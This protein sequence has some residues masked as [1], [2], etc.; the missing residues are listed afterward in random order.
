MTNSKL[1]TL[2]DG[3]TIPSFGFGT[4]KLTGSEGQKAMEFALQNGYRLIDTA[5]IYQ[6]EIEVGNAIKNSGISR[7]EIFVTSKVWRSDLG[8]E[9][10][11]KACEESLNRLQLD[12]LDLYLIHW[13]ANS[14]HF[15]NWKELNAETWRALEELQ[16]QGKVK[17]IGVSNFLVEHLSELLKTAKTKPTVNQIE[18]HPGYWQEDTTTFCKEN[19]I[20]VEAWSPIARG[21]ALSKDVITQLAEKYDK[22]PAQIVFRWIM[23]QQIIPIPKS[24]TEHRILENKDVFDFNLTEEEINKMKSIPEFGF[25]G[26]HPNTWSL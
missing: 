19:D 6:N 18:F 11:L 15:P 26:Y 2:N 16:Q 25:S 7:D 5:S 10:T 9:A 24:Q 14:K 8:F 1:I 13:P 3:N 17:S 22:T 12:Y 21:E 20:V 23:D 4:Y